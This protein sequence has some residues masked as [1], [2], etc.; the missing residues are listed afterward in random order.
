MTRW[1]VDR[2][3]AFVDSLLQ[4]GGGAIV[5]RIDVY[6]VRRVTHHILFR[7]ALPR[8]GDA[9]VWRG[10]SCRK[11]MWLQ[12]QGV[13]VV[14]LQVRPVASTSWSCYPLTLTHQFDR[15]AESDLTCVHLATLNLT[16]LLT[17]RVMATE[18]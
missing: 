1:W 15:P 7:S 2:V 6:K 16:P 18:E 11:T 17:A 13:Y 3:C 4:A 5:S 12:L 9:V 14:C 10:L 8:W